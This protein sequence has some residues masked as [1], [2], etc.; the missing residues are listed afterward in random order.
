MS[1]IDSILGNKIPWK[2]VRFFIENPSIEVSQTEMIE[3]LK[4]AK[5]SAVKWL[6]ILVESKFIVKK[7][8]GRTNIYKLDREN[9]IVKQIKILFTMSVLLPKMPKIDGEIYLFGSSARGEDDEKSDID[10]LVIGKDR[11]II[12]KIQNANKKIKVIFF[13]QIDWSRISRDDAA[14]YERV[15]KDRIRLV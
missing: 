9:S 15:E 2:I 8:I 13:T 1:D 7:Q 12:N 14:F 5:M 3:K 4:I 11:S 6:N 10:I